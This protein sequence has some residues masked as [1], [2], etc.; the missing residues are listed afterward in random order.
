MAAPFTKEIFQNA[1]PSS[2]TV[3]IN[4][5]MAFDGKFMWTTRMVGTNAEIRIVD[6][7]GPH[8]SLTDIDNDE[9][10][11]W[12]EPTVDEIT[13][14]IMGPEGFEKIYGFKTFIVVGKTVR[15]FSRAEAGVMT[16]I[17][18]DDT[19]NRYSLS[20]YALLTSV[21]NPKTNVTHTPPPLYS[22][23]FLDE[24]GVAFTPSAKCILTNTVNR[25]Y[26]QST[27]FYWTVKPAPSTQTGND[28]QWLYRYSVVDGSYAGKTEIPGRKQ[29]IIRHLSISGDYI[30]VGS[31][32][33]RGVY[34]FS[35]GT[36]ALVKYIEVNRDVEEMFEYGGDI[37]VSSRNAL[38]SKI[39]AG[40]TVTDIG[41]A[42]TRNYYWALLT[43]TTI[44]PDYEWFKVHPDALNRY[45]AGATVWEVKTEGN[46]SVAVYYNK[47]TR[48]G[49]KLRFYDNT[50]RSVGYVPEFTYQYY[51]NGSFTTVL[52]PAHLI[53]LKSNGLTAC[54]RF[55]G[56]YM[57][58][59]NKSYGGLMAISTGVQHYKG[60]QI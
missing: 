56:I 25:N 50:V 12:A 22:G 60:D 5:P 59:I 23:P 1:P 51:T 36:G 10:P 18:T 11:R 24:N 21:S 26:A 55:P 46:D 29:D 58:A 40:F 6:F 7:W 31:Y 17:F 43:G 39:T 19:W 8:L 28:T 16:V 47:N 49:G 15:Q 3:T 30:Y 41:N 2:R 38:F 33:N 32:N 44:I 54:V 48:L 45:D 27:N 57:G 4:S 34:A 35:L 14:G 53:F 52:V 20:T 37:F 13:M 42:S 9:Y